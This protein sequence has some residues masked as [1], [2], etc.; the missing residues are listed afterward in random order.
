M[1]MDDVE[2]FVA[3]R[4]DGAQLGRHVGSDGGDRTVGRGR[5]ASTEWGHANIGRWTVTGAEDTNVVARR[6]QRPGKAEYLALHASRKTQG[7]RRDDADSHAVAS[8]V[9]KPAAASAS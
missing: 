9:G 6:A 7:V 2:R 4:A 8:S 5:D 3:Q 1:K